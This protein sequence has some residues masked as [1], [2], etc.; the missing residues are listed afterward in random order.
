MM[1]RSILQ[2]DITILN[3]YGPSNR[4]SKYM[5]QKLID[6]QGE[7]DDSTITVGDFFLLVVPGLSCGSL[8]A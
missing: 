2:E 8:V 5:R 4:V 3:V 7:I 1:K 6:L